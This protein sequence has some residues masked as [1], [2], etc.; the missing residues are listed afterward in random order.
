MKSAWSKFD[1]SLTF[2][3]VARSCMI[4]PKGNWPDNYNYYKKLYSVIL[5]SSWLS[6]LFLIYYFIY[7]QIEQQ[8]FSLIALFYGHIEHLFIYLFLN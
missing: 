3:Y 1:T 4:C 7:G 2:E 5:F 8:L 6:N